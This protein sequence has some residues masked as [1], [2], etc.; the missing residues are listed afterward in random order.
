MNQ[1]QFLKQYG[2]LILLQ[3]AFLIWTGMAAYCYQERLYS[4]AGF[5]M[6]K[7]VHYES[8]WVEAGR[9]IL[10]FSQ[11]LPLL[12]VKLGCSM[13]VVLMAYSVGH[14]LFYYGI[15]LFCHWYWKRGYV[16]WWL[17][18]I[19]C[20][21]IVHGF[22]TPTFE[23]YYNT[24]FLVLW[25]VL[26]IEEKVSGKVLVAVAV[27]SGFVIIN[28]ILALIF[29]G[30]VL[31]L[32]ATQQRLKAWPIA[33]ATGVGIALGFLLKHTLLANTYEAAKVDWF[34]H[35]FQHKDFSWEGYIQPWLSFY[36]PYYWE[37][38]VI[39]GGTLVYYLKQKKYPTACTYFLLVIATQYVISLTYPAIKHS[40]Y[41]EQCYFPLMMITCYPLVM[42]ILPALSKKAS[43]A[44]QVGVF[45]LISYRFW[46]IATGIQPFQLR[47]AYLH[48]MIET[49]RTQGVYKLIMEEESLNSNVNDPS[50][51]FGMESLLLSALEPEKR[52]VQVIRDTEWAHA[53]NAQT[54]QDSSLYLATYRSYYERPDSFYQHKTANPS[55]MNFP[56]SPY[57]PVR[58]RYQPFT[59][60]EQLKN[61][62]Q[63]TPELEES[64]ATSTTLNVPLNIHNT[65]H[66]AWSS[67]GVL[68]AYHWWQQDT[69]VHW[70]G[71]RSVL[72]I[73][74]LAQQK[75]QQY[76]VVHTP[77]KAGDYILQIDF[78][79]PGELG[80]CHNPNNHPLRIEE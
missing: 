51:T 22:C 65:S 16:G 69:V 76:I 62:I 60:L 67:A 34:W 57:Y 20:V 54:L 39:M 41:Q 31:L 46:V 17:I 15:Y 12:C 9:Y 36:T 18:L 80:W 40:R 45:L 47:V 24:G 28:Y 29:F 35:Q 26:L 3:L 1:Q 59:S 58:G 21:G 44:L 13:K 19:Q 74:L 23:L 49:G 6:A 75:H 66:Q 64:Y 68:I 7:V 27:L 2:E 10:V 11:W 70:E 77:E 50:F 53:N 48:R 5:Y 4:D 30:G 37:L 72:E 55:Y 14:V 71:E 42:D 79:A 43:Y 38:L 78:I 63:Y 56:P 25:G 8:F 32:H 52:A 73:D 61:S 33:A